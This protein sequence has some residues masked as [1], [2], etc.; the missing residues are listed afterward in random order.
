MIY[1]LQVWVPWGGGRSGRGP[2]L[3]SAHAGAAPGAYI[4]CRTYEEVNTLPRPPTCSPPRHPRPFGMRAA[5]SAKTSKAQAVW[6]V[7]VP[8]RARL[9]R[10]AG[11]R[12]RAPD[13]TE[14][15]RAAAA[16]PGG[17]LARAPEPQPGVLPRGRG[18]KQGL[19]RTLAE[20]S[21]EMH[22]QSATRRKNKEEP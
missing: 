16:Q 1:V 4:R 8:V 6:P 21:E 11:N 3:G 9:A 18:P 7:C 22:A 19:E 14:T 15:R 20:E 17:T 13:K 12:P 2:S 5:R 10:F